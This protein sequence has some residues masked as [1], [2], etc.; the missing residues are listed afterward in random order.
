MIFT[1]ITDT[2]WERV[3]ASKVVIDEGVLLFEGYDGMP[4]RIY[5][6]G[7]WKKVFKQ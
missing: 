2:E 4:V 3:E 7:Q 5:A 6:K 1:V